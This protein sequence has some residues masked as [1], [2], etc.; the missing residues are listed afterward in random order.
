MRY[1]VA[2]AK[3]FQTDGEESAIDPTSELDVYLADG[4]VAEKTFVER[5]E[6]ASQHSQEVLDEDDA[7]LAVATPEVWEYTVVDDRVDE[8][9]DAML[10]SQTVMEYEVVDE[11][12]TTSDEAT[13]VA[14]GDGDTRVPASVA[15]ENL[16]GPAA[17]PTGEPN[18]NEAGEATEG[19]RI[20]TA[21]DP[22]LGL[23][24]SGEPGADWAADTGPSRGP[25]SGAE[26]R[27][28]GTK[29]STL[30]P[31][32]EPGRKRKRAAGS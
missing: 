12:E 17:T 32:Q 31:P 24:D 23:T 21:D 22:T 27:D 16:E 14:L 13:A 20:T 19:M 4:V 2:F 18:T 29:K 8:F 1:R 7:F 15:F 25:G 3:R 26:T 11:T 28:I 6:P 9:K 10:N 30:T 5:L